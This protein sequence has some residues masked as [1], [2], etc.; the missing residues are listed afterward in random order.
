MDAVT[1]PQEKVGAFFKEHL[2]PLRM[3]YN[4]ENL[5]PLFTVSWTP[6]LISLDPSGGEH[7]RTTG[8]MDA[9]VLLASLLLGIA[10]VHM[11]E[12][13][14]DGALHYLDAL[15][16]EYPE[17][18]FIPEAVY[19]EGVTRYKQSNDPGELKKAYLQLQEKF[20]ASGWF[21]RAAPYRHL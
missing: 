17:S 4:D 19:F 14:F 6:A 3:T 20:P 9:D 13:R 11:S 10:K 8:F 2:V 21:Q 5:T 15:F 12:G 18:E 1:Y 7:Q 16:T